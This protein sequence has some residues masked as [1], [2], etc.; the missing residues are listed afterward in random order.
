MDCPIV[1]D[2]LGHCP[3]HCNQ[4]RPESDMGPPKSS[5]ITSELGQTLLGFGPDPMLVETSSEISPKEPQLIEDSLQYSLQIPVYKEGK[6]ALKEVVI[7]YG[8][9]GIEVIKTAYEQIGIYIN[10]VDPK[11]MGK[12]FVVNNMANW[13]AVKAGSATKALAK[14]NTTFRLRLTQAS[15]KVRSLSLD[16]PRS[17]KIP[18]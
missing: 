13:Y 4:Y 11:A 12:W 1:H 3:S 14:V 5:S 8:L 18:A 2:I 10:I 7:P 15:Q 9:S 6:W 16:V 17:N